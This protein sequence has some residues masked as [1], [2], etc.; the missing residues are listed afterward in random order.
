MLKKGAALKKQAKAQDRVE[1]LSASIAA[2]NPARNALE[3][4]MYSVKQMI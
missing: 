4:R 3:E 2:K 1:R